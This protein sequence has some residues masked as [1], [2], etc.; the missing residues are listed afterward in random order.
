VFLASVCLES[1]A[2]GRLN[3]ALSLF[4]SPDVF[5]KT[6][7]IPVL[8]GNQSPTTATATA[9]ATIHSNFSYDNKQQRR[10]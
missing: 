9:T 8:N 4:K 2:K 1:E 5:L 6:V 7:T 3:E 10:P